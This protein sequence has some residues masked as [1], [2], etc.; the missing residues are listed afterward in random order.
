MSR[1]ATAGKSTNTITAYIVVRVISG[2]QSCFTTPNHVFA[3]RNAAH[4]HSDELNRQLR[5]I[6][7]PFQHDNHPDNTMTGGESAFLSLL[8]KLKL[9]VP[10]KRTDYNFIDW[11]AWWD[12]YY[13]DMTH[14]QREAI[15]NALDRFN[16]YHVREVEME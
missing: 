6:T 5:A 7:G 11:A 1:K 4:A 9:P 2:E 8:K 14:E 16:W 10:K 13:F 15:W 12:R 3:D